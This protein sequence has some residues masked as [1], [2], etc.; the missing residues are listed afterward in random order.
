MTAGWT[1]WNGRWRARLL[2]AGCS[3]VL[4]VAALPLAAAGQVEPREQVTFTND[5]APILQR[6]CQRCHRPDSLAPMSL[7]DYEEVRPWARSIKHRTGLRDKPGAMP[8]WYVE[9]D[10]GIQRFKNDPSLSDEEIAKIAAWADSGAPLG[11]PA[12]MPPPMA[13]ID[14]DEWEIGQPDLV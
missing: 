10:I 5:I 9:K 4:G 7:I 2:A 6:S 13:F 12:D 1:G 3:A 11:D 8:P 14:V